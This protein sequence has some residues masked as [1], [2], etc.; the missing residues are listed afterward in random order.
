VKCRGKSSRLGK[1]ARHFVQQLPQSQRAV[2]TI[3]DPTVALDDQ[4]NTL[5]N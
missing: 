4:G 1:L 3:Y 2:P 5:V